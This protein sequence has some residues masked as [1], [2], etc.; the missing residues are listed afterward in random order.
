MSAKYENEPTL[1][2]GILAAPSIVVA[3]HGEF[4]SPEGTLNGGEIKNS[5]AT[6]KYCGTALNTTV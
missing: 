6:A 2:V 5:A 3:L 4:S 1:R